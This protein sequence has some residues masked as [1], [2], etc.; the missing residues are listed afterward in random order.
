MGVDIRNFER[1]QFGAGIAKPEA[2]N[3]VYFCQFSVF[4]NKVNGFAGMID[5]KLAEHQFF[6]HLSAP[7]D[8]LLTSAANLFE[9]AA[10]PSQGFLES[11]IRR[12]EFLDYLIKSANQRGGLIV[13][14]NGKR[15]QIQL[16]CVID[17]TFEMRGQFRQILPKMTM[18]SHEQKA[19]HQPQF[20]Q[21]KKK[22]LKKNIQVNLF[23][24]LFEKSR[25]LR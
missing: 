6:F 23:A 22:G 13:A 24:E 14:L 20:N 3:L 25:Y 10:L 2:G 16:A 8:F 1:K 17:K 7:L 9:R 18:A 4:L 21:N 12:L 5:D 11:L 15:L 19:N